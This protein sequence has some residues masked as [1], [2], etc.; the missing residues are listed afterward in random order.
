[1]H[2]ICIS[3]GLSIE[4]CQP[5]TASGVS[6]ELAQLV[7]HGFSFPNHSGCKTD[8]KGEPPIGVVAIAAHTSRTI[9]QRIPM[10][11]F[12]SPQCPRTPFF[13]SSSHCW[14]IKSLI[15]P[16]SSGSVWVHGP[17]TPFGSTSPAT[18]IRNPCIRCSGAAGLR[19]KPIS[20]IPTAKEGKKGEVAKKSERKKNGNKNESAR[21][22]SVRVSAFRPV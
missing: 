2:Q 18:S 8:A 14:I 1:M 13:K 12:A 7:P 20:L 9:I 4:N 5:T 10:A 6:A 21:E 19:R 16:Q 11:Q 17:L 3:G 22:A 15:Y